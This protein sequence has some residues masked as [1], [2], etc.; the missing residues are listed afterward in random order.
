MRES[1]IMLILAHSTE[2]GVGSIANAF[3]QKNLVNFNILQNND[4]ADYT[5]IIVFNCSPRKQ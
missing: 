1:R 3:K 4:D 5:M 2:Q